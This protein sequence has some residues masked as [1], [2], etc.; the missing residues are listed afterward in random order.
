MISGSACKTPPVLA[1]FDEDAPTMLHTDASNVG[2]GAVLVQWQ[3][4]A[5]RVIAYASRTLSRAECNYSTTEKECLAVV[6]AVMKFRPYLYG[7][8]FSV[9]SDHHSF[10]G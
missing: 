9:V 10:A 2:L 8:S 6:W 4:S 7:R 5:E 3:D 1:H